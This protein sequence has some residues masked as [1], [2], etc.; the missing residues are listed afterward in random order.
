MGMCHHQL[1][2]V[3]NIYSLHY[4]LSP[5]DSDI[6]T[7]VENLLFMAY[8]TQFLLRLPEIS[9]QKCELL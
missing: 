4:I 2:N 9:C 5:R 3:F 1:G 8:E 6:S 7:S